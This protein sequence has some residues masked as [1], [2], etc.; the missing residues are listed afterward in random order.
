MTTS[1]IIIDWLQF[2][3]L[4]DDGLD[5]VIKILRQPKDD[6]ISLDK[7]GLG[8]KQQ[9]YNNNIR[10]YYD[11]NVGMGVCASI[12]GQACRYL[13]CKGIDLWDLLQKLSRS[14]K[15]NITRLDIALDY[16]QCMMHKIVDNIKTGRYI[17]KSRKIN[18][19][20]SMVGKKERVETI[21]I[22]SRSS[23][24]MIR[25]YNKALEQHIDN[26][27]WERYEIVLKKDRIYKV[28][29]MLANSISKTFYNILYTYFRP[30]VSVE[31][32]ISRS[33]I[34]PY[35]MEFLGQVLKISL[36]SKKEQKTIQDKYNWLEKQVA[37]TMAMLSLALENTDFLAAIARQNIYRLKDKEYDLIN[38]F[39]GD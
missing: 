16:Y 7:G 15:I 19:I 26:I 23:D 30:V 4:R 18:F 38:K 22:G 5:T 37:P 6:Y 21:Y 12:T 2:T 24:V 36:F 32:N 39:K 27:T 11:G 10:L 33:E 25:I 31:R 13:E 8:Y 34:E 20:S 3:L 1:R 35:Y 28:I 17:S 14:I 29:P 9:L